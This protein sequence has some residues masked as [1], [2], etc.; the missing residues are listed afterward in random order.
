MLATCGRSRH[1]QSQWVRVRLCVPWALQVVTTWPWGAGMWARGRV[2]HSPEVCVRVEAHLP[3]TLS[4]DHQWPPKDIITL[5]ALGCLA[6]S[7]LKFH[8]IFLAQ[9]TRLYGVANKANQISNRHLQKLNW[10][11]A[12][13]VWNFK[14]VFFWA[15]KY[16]IPKIMFS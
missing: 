4:A 12:G 13:I 3:P 9:E 16:Y 10:A 14:N 11:E 2:G 1:V 5:C 7:S 15:T 6:K 8:F